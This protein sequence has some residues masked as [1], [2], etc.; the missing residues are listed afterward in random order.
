MSA[1]LSHAAGVVPEECISG[2][3]DLFS[4]PFMETTVEN[5]YYT[6]YFPTNAISD[7]ANSIAFHIPPTEDMV[8]L[9]ESYVQVRCKIT[10]A[11]GSNLDAY[12]APA[13]GSTSANS[14][15]FVQMPITSMFSSLVFR[16]N[17]ELLTD[18]FAT[19][20]Y[21]AYFQTLLNFS[22]DATESR[23][24]LLGF[25]KEKRMNHTAAHATA[26]ASGFKT[27][28]GLTAQSHEATFIGPIFQSMFSQSRF[29]LPLTK[30]SL[31]WIKA[32]PAFC[33]KS[34]NSTADYLYKITSMKLFLRKIK[35]RPSYKLELEQQLLK[36]PAMYPLRQAYCKPFFIDAEE[37]QVSFENVFQSRSIPAYCAIAICDQT[38]YRGAYGKSPFQFDHHSLT[39]LKISVDSDVY[40]S[41]TPFQPDFVSTTAPNWTREYLALQDN[42][43]KV[44][45]GNGIS[46]DMFANHFAIYVIHFGRLSSLANDHTSPKRAGSARL[47]VSFAS[48]S[49]NPALTLLL[50]AESD[51]T[52]FLDR[53]RQPSRD[54][55]L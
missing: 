26:P 4:P 2:S 35:I 49:T 36:E 17:D 13:S 52:L 51:E 38:A 8:D 33:L 18:S 12:A 32:S 37:K 5:A 31:E 23:L 7:S 34:N 42:Q 16:L 46:Y 24:Q 19:Y 6:E 44:D 54:F 45:A 40:P 10:K 41:P 30:M 53:N 1:R 15:G 48:T 22:S 9:A 27:R 14:V 43:I 25:Y 28:A 55:H 11:D 29:L 47:D 3:L 21:L 20:P 39:S 50:Y